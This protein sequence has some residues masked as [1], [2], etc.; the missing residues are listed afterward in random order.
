MSDKR[1]AV[2]I[3]VNALEAAGVTK[4][5]ALKAAGGT[6]IDEA[7]A[8]W[9]IEV[10]TKKKMESSI[11][12]LEKLGLTADKDVFPVTVDVPD[13][14]HHYQSVANSMSEHGG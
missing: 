12:K 4:A 9:T 10:K 13:W 1:Y 2:V 6:V 3:L 8:S 14:L 5:K 7:E 11:S